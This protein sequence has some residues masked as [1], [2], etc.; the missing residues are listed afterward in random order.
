MFCL[1]QKYYRIPWPESQKYD[2]ID[3]DG[4]HTVLAADGA[5]LF[6]EKEWIDGLNEREL[7]W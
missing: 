5:E 3:P 4:E 7:P 2:E 1:Y 6:A